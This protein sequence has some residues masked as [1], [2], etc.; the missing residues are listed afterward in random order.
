MSQRGLTVD[1]A[2]ID[3]TVRAATIEVPGVLRIGRGGP[4]WRTWIGGSP[5]RTRVEDGRVTVRIWLVARP[6]QSLPD[7]SAKV[8]I[9]VAASVER[10]LGLELESVTVVVDG[11]GG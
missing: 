5:V 8:R 11:V 3:E 4:A 1:R 6:G 7:L 10:L 9:A 2:V